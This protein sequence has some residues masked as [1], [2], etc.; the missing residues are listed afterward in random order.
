MRRWI[1]AISLC[2][3]LICSPRKL[4]T[5][6]SPFPLPPTI[7]NLVNLVT[8]TAD[9]TKLSGTIPT[10]IGNPWRLTCATYSGRQ[11]CVGN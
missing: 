1:M 5:I 9:N 3:M 11:G 8:F 6:L 7:G 4:G 10:Q 2:S